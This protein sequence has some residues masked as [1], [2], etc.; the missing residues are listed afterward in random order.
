MKKGLLISLMAFVIMLGQNALAQAEIIMTQV[1]TNSYEDNSPQIR[2]NYLV[3]QGQVGGDWEV[4]L[5]NVVTEEGPVQV[6]DNSHDDISPQTDGNYLVWLGFG[7]PDS[8][9]F[10]PGGEIFLYEIST[11]ETTRITTDSNVDS[12]PQIADGK[13]AW[14]S[15]VVGDSVEPGEIFLYDISTGVTE[16]LTYNTLDDSS[17]RIDDQSVVWVQADVTGLTSLFIHHLGNGTEPVPEGFIWTDSPQNDGNL[18]VLTRYDGNDREIF[19]QSANIGIDEQI[20][21][22]DFE[23][24]HPRI[25]GNRI[26]WMAGKARDR[27]IYLATYTYTF[28][29]LVSPEN[30]AILPKKGPPTFTWN[31]IGYEKFKVQFSKAPDFPSKKTLTLPGGKKKWLSETF[32]TPTD[33]KWS[34][35][36]K[37]ERKNR[38][39]YWR[40]K[41]KDADGNVAF[42]EAWGFSVE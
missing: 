18:S 37:M 25:S 5:Y 17:P 13:V 9:V 12:L 24:I 32:F 19:V 31:T 36:K 4:F 1:T 35:I 14:A 22:N 21:D 3:W 42:S 28:L 2:G 23:D 34:A 11:G 7:D 6:T 30:G 20:T 8:D 26:A 16:Q 15:H 33:S 10:V 27:E 41:A 29:G 38:Y 39:V 40:V